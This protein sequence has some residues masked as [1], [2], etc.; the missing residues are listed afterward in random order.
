[1]IRAKLTQEAE[2]APVVATKVSAKKSTITCT[3]GKTTKKV[4]GVKP[5]CPAGFRKK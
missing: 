5:K 4:S 3:K 2:V 1:V